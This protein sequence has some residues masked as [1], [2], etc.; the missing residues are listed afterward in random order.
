MAVSLVEPDDSD[1]N[2]LSSKKALKRWV[3]EIKYYETRARAWES[4]GKKI[5][6]RYKDIR[7]PR[8]AMPARFNILWSNIQTMLPCLYSRTPKPDIERRYR[9]QDD[10]GRV[11]SSVL[12]RSITFFVGEQFNAAVKQAILDR[13]LPGRGTVWARYEPHFKDVTVDENE[14]VA[15]DG[16]QVT[17]DV[18]SYGE[19]ETEASDGSGDEGYQEVA[20]EAVCW[21]YVHWED[22]GHTYGRTWDEVDAGWRKVY[23]SRE[24]LVERFGEKGET[25]PLDYSPT[26]V[27]DAKIDET[28]K[29]ATIYEIWCKPDKKAIW[30]HKD[31]EEGILD[32]QDDPLG[33]QDFWPFPKPLFATLANDD[34][35]PTPDYSEY[36]DQ[37]IELDELTSRIASITKA[38]KVAGVYDASAEG[39]QRLLAEGTENQLIPVEQF[40]ML[41]EKGGLA[42]VMALM[43][44]ND[45]LQTLLGLYEA[46][47]KVKADLYEITGM[48][49]II[50]GASDPDE[51]AAAQEIK[52]RFGTLRLQAQQD[53]VQ[54]FVR[55]LVKIGTEIIAGHFGIDTIKRIS[56]VKL[57]TSQEK[58]LVQANVQAKQQAS[59]MGHN[60]GPP[61]SPQ[62]P[63]AQA[64]PPM[65]QPPPP[66]PLPP[67]IA[68]IDPEDMEEM[69]NDPSWEEVEQLL[70]SEP[71]LAYKID[72]E[73]DSTIKFDQEAEQQQR[74]QFLAAAGG[75]LQQAMQ[76]QNPDLEPLLAKMLMFGIRGFKIGKDL[77][78]AFEVAIRK[79]EKDNQ[80]PTKKKPD[81]EMAKIQ[82]QAQLQQQK[83]QGDMQLEQLRQKNDQQKIMLDAQAEEHRLQVQ[84]Q[85][86]TNQAKLDAQNEQLKQQLD[87]QRDDMDR[88]MDQWKAKLEAE[89]KLA[90]AQIQ[91]KTQLQTTAMG[92]EGS[93]VSIDAD[94]NPIKQ[95]STS[96]L[97]TTVVQ[98]L[99][100]ALAGV[101]QS[102][103][104]LAQAINKPKQVIRD[105]IT[106]KIVGVH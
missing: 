78:S 91:A 19:T 66:P 68:K 86:D 103:Q 34:C 44:M 60:G 33:L 69:M 102:H 12:E 84:A 1:D 42:G 25:V 57:F 32:E 55:D 81:P 51:T 41:S 40:A 4:K 49:D 14:E 105:P 88:Q 79:L 90:V 63:T 76:N 31:F 97:M 20:D 38:V 89:T 74:T 77:E 83:M 27:K 94:G 8:E 37:A 101:A 104:T 48:A 23:M 99:Q 80:D 30:L 106:D 73:T 6:R 93:G 58:S 53:D 36:Q 15:D 65:M 52:S 28:I 35:L 54:R 24:E 5:I 3:Q 71:L 67:E 46:R 61:M 22:F 39:V 7:S 64:Q 11:T 17:D 13:L 100:E 85:V 29:K 56:G 10:I 75:F 16:Y 92:Q 95:A 43:P 21:D 18:D 2:D 45:I 87:K 9:D 82:S 72:I 62:A 59:M 70:K 47:D 50:R 98:Q 26:D 96:D